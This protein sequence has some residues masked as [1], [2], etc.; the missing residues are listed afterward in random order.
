M[1]S[2]RTVRVLL[3]LTSFLPGFA[4]AAAAPNIVL[5]LADDL[6]Y[7]D[8]GCYGSEIQTPHLDSLAA[9]GL[10]FRNF[11]N[12]GRCSPSRAALLTG[13]YQH[14]AGVG[15]LDE[16]WQLHGYRGFLNRESVTLAEVL[17]QAGYHT[18]MSGKWHLGR[19]RPH[20]PI[21]RGFDRMFSSPHG[22][23]Y[24][25]RPFETA[26]RPLY[27][28][29][30]LVDLDQW[31]TTDNNGQPFYSTD[32]FTTMGLEFIDE[33]LAA[34]KPFFLYLSYIA[35]HF[36][37]EAYRADVRKYL[38][39]DHTTTPPTAGTG[40]YEN[41]YTPIRRFRLAKQKAAGG[42][43]A[44]LNGTNGEWS[45][46]P[47]HGS[48]WKGGRE[49]ER[50]MA[51]HA[52]VIDRMDQQI[53]LVLNK[54]DNPDGDPGT[55]DSIADNTI[56]LFVSDNGG[57][58]SGGSTGRGSS[59]DPAY[60]STSSK[61]RYGSSW[62][63]VSNTPF[64]RFKSSTQEGGIQTPFLIRWP[65]GI[66]RPGNEVEA[67]R[68]HFIDLLPTLLDSAGVRYPAT[69][70]GH[71][72]QPAEGISLRPLFAPGG[73]VTRSAPLYFE[74]E[75]ERALIDGEGWKLMSRHKAAWELYYLPHDPQELDDRAASE[76]ARVTTM[77][78]DWRAWAQAAHVKDYPPP[79]ASRK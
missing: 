76:S 29:E 35:P 19:K 23:G 27:L 79:G 39:H 37:L 4:V 54:L 60:G 43:A 36:P 42:I 65:N 66:T 48:S 6:G 22:G 3:V 53:G 69:Y 46:S 62:A 72:I 55:D 11:Y 52:A 28:D 45:L 40:T 61:V 9:D 67:T 5:I 56:V 51:L 41:G 32:A 63:N 24:Y 8:L 2:S 34:D 58:S 31:E 64:R 30:T 75:G 13:R 26:N 12:T 38:D 68:G 47:Q 57:A 49:Q 21:D 50:Y 33:A 70:Q 18:S 16:D 15:H 14:Q 17:Q 74:H 25:F 10:R 44:G 78:A 77:A 71:A 1:M 59:G 20:W 73:T 7:S